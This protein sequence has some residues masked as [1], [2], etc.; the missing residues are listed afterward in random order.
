MLPRVATG[1]CLLPAA[2]LPLGTAQT[3]NGYR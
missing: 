2:L 3:A 1:L